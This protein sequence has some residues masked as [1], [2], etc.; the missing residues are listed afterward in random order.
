M[1][2]A[3]IYEALAIFYLSRKIE[4]LGIVWGLEKGGGWA[5]P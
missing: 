1:A 5:S 3:W 4:R 2:G